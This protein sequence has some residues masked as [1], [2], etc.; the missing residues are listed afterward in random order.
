MFGTAA[1]LWFG[2]TQQSYWQVGNRE[3]SSLFRETN[4]QP[5][6]MLVH[7]LQA[8]LAVFYFRYVSAALVH[9]SNGR[10]SSLSRSWNRLIGDLAIESGPW[11]LQLRPWA[12]VFS[13]ADDRDDNP[14][15]EDYIDVARWWRPI[16][17]VGRVDNDGPPYLRAATGRAARLDWALP[18]TSG[19]NGHLQLFPDSAT[20]SSTKTIARPISA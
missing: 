9:E 11:S 3:E 18:L 15:I 12:R 13:G 4:Y 6:A 5:E 19:S 10:G 1:D 7:P 14:D 17:R 2:Y 8:K 16:E 20:A